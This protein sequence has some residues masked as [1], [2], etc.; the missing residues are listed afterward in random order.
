MHCDDFGRDGW[1]GAKKH[2]KKKK[3]VNKCSRD[4]PGFFWGGCLCV[5]SLPHKDWPQKHI[6]RFFAPTQSRENPA[7]LFMFM[8]FSFPWG[9]SWSLGR[10]KRQHNLTETC[11][12]Y[13]LTENHSEAFKWGRPEGS[14]LGKWGRTQM[15]SDGFITWFGFF[16]PIGV[17]L[18]PFIKTHDVKRFRPD[19]NHL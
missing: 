4:C 15:G 8:R 10:G 17:R 1:L 9:K 18:V 2:T 14:T 13:E 7:N 6:N 12:N 16:S 5:F 3:H 19:F 11:Y